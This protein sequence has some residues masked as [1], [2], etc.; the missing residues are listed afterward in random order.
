M[1]PLTTLKMN[2]MLE[3]INHKEGTQGAN[4]VWFDTFFISA[5]VQGSAIKQQPL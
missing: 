2:L 5:A 3:T 1:Y 4:C